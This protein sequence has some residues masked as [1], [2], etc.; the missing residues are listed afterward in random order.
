MRH[1]RTRPFRLASAAVLAVAAV[2]LSGCTTDE[3]DATSTP[4]G[5][6]VAY[7]A[8]KEEYIA[9][10]EDVDPVTLKFQVSGPE[11][12]LA[13]EGVAAYAA[14]V[15]EWSGGKIDFE[16]GYANSF[17][18]AATEWAAGLADGRIDIGLFLPYYTPDVFP[19]FNNLT[20]ATF[21]D[22][23]APTSTLISSAWV[24][25][26]AYSLPVY[27]EEAAANG[28]HVLALGPSVSF[29]GV[30]C[31]EERT[32]LEDF[33]GVQ[34]SASGSGRVEQLTAL[35]FSPQS[36]AFTELYEALERGVVQCGST[37]PTALDS[38]G[39]VDLVPYMA[40]DPEAALVGFP[41]FIAIGA[42]KWNA[43]PL[44]AQQLM[45]DRLDAFLAAEAPG[46]GER[47]TEWLEKAQ[48]A[49]GGILPL[50]D[51]ARTALLAA[52]DTLLEQMKS[53]GV[54]TDALTQ[55]FTKWKG[56][57]N[58]DLYPD[59]TTDLEEFLDAG[60]YGTLDYQPFV[61]AVFEQFL[62][63]HRP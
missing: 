36:I 16:W 54:D 47:V 41:S 50:S 1:T 23:N 21:L 4:T 56:L 9:A 8:S 19:E 52:N 29:A 60:G 38:I 62:R 14:A 20:N 15:T 35:G 24:T 59:V 58:D 37:V 61:D 57:I 18:P 6:G 26:A 33:E 45:T 27:E 30:F 5:E 17:V 40:A 46:Q 44:V 63:E 39:A 3:G 51:D 25:E 53:E 7:G 34:I 22:G 13:N 42:E 31:S 49:G 12:S 11:G 55:I 10:F 43:L 2:A 32:S 48:A 28:I